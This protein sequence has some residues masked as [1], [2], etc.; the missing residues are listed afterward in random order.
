MGYYDNGQ[1]GGYTG[2]G[3]PDITRVTNPR[4]PETDNYLA[5]NFFQLEITRLPTV[6]YFCQGVGL[7]SIT[8]T[9]VEQPIP[10]GLFPK[11]VGGKYAFEDLTVNFLVDENMKNWLEVFEW[12]KDIGNMEDYEEVIDSKQTPDF[13]SDILLVVT[14]SV[15]RPNLHIRFKDTFPIALS[16]FEFTSI[17][18]DTEP[19][20]ASATFAYTS[21][22]I[23][24]V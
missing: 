12:M 20:T 9:P 17:A 24:S 15:Y 6:T 4:Q 1:T 19:I 3:I 5:N 2:P 22:E 7:P 13:F 21:Y 23:T 11:W 10:L 14:N 18:T 16:G 8:L